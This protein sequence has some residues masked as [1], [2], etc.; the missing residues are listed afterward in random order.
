MPIDERGAVPEGIDPVTGLPADGPWRDRTIVE[1]VRA[2]LRLLTARDRRMYGLASIAQMTLGLLDLAGVALIGAIGAVAVSG[3]S[4]TTLPGPIRN[5]QDSL[6]LTASQFIGLLAGLAVLLLVAKT[7]ASAYITRRM[8][9]FLAFRQATVAARLARALLARPLLEVQRWSTSEVLYALTS[10]VSAAVTSLLGAALIIITEVA[11][12]TLLGVGLLIID[13]LLTLAAAAYFAVIVLLLQLAL[14]RLSARNAT[15]L[16]DRNMS[17]ITTVSEALSTYRETTVLDRRSFYVD[18]F[19]N[20]TRQGAHAGSTNAFLIEV[21][22]YILETA[23]VVGAFLLA[24]IQFL[25]Q[26]LA[27]AAALVA[28]FL[29]AGFRIVPA[30]L[31]MQGAALSIRT[32]AAA[33]RKT[34]ELALFFGLESGSTPQGM[35]PQDAQRMRE[36]IAAG[37]GSFSGGV[38]VA[39][40]SLTYPGADQ[41]AL[42]DVSL[43]V[44][45]GRSLALVGSTGAGKST[46]ADVIL[47][48]VEP[49]IGRVLVSGEEPRLAVQRWP[50]AVAYV[51]QSVGLA[52]GTIRE[53]VALGLPDEAIDDDW[54]WA[55][56]E[57]AHLAMFLREKR[58]GLDTVIGERGVRL[59]GGQR[60]RLGIAR[61][62][63]S[64]P[65]LLVL[66]EATSALDAETEQA[67][68]QTLRGLEGEVTTVTIAHRLATIRF[69]D[70]VVFL[71]HGVIEARGSFADVRSS[72]PD[73][74]R[75]AELL[76]L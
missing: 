43:S 27:T 30:L 6:G 60:Q 21:P 67:I 26:D 32:A 11:L 15:I 22:K 42:R 47:G 57:R 61:A 64:R 12:F 50:G 39:A 10:G 62:L 3:F 55:A 18:R 17:T 13:P 24:I 19:E 31:R 28:V 41:P 9:R 45:P 52:D 5:V 74:D 69:V 54:V 14:G 49:D 51:P 37:H 56:L 58:E 20:L 63:Y 68:T 75:Q 48:V 35:Q 33:A 8:F 7:L 66:D 59:S 46:L 65:K 25:T 72:V 71:R 4:P 36:Q 40:V 1:S 53:N 34:F 70:E 76:G 2:S 38:E 29:A 23:L 16:A 73:F 44:A